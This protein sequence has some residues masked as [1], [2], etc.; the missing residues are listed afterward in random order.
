MAKSW[1]LRIVFKGSTCKLQKQLTAEKTFG[2]IV[3]K[4]LW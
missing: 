2:Q 3:V 1:Y 4:N